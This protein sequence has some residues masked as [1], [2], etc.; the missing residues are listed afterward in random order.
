MSNIIWKWNETD[1][2]QFETGSIV[3]IRFG[4]ALPF[5][6][7]LFLEKVEFNGEPALRLFGSAATFNKGGLF[8]I[9]N[10]TLPS[11]YSIQIELLSRSVDS[12]SDGDWPL[13]FAIGG[14]F[15]TGNALIAAE[16]YM[17]TTYNWTGSI[18]LNSLGIGFGSNGNFWRSNAFYQTFVNMKPS[19]QYASG[20]FHVG[21][22]KIGFGGDFDGAA[23]QSNQES[24]RSTGLGLLSS[25]WR[26]DEFND[27]GIG[28]GAYGT[29]GSRTGSLWIRD[30]RILKHPLDL[31]FDNY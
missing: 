25:S 23:I 8:Q 5:T 30:I 16:S 27:V 13:N 4:N 2:S 7:S 31:E 29:G 9:K 6:G 24:W 26:G 15:T 18:V 21:S 11:R 19:S 14:N 22:I 28:I 3:S 20:A 10:L 12:L 1:V 17:M